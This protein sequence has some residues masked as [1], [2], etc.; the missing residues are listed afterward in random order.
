MIGPEQQDPVQ[1]RSGRPVKAVAPWLTTDFE[2]VSGDRQQADGVG[3]S[4]VTP[5]GQLPV[6]GVDLAV[7]GDRRL[8]EVAMNRLMPDKQASYIRNSV[9]ATVDAY[10]GTVTL[11]APG[12]DRPGA[13]GLGE[14]VSPAR[15]AEAA[16]SANGTGCAPALSGGP[17]PRC[18]VAGQVPRRRPDD[19]L[20]DIGLLGCRWIPTRPRRATSRRSL[21]S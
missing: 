8:T 7:V 15:Q 16:T 2:H 14:A 17:V 4:T 3:S 6:L 19:V 10:D 11:Y 13:A 12:R 9:K 18:S 20:L 5:P 1:P 21:P